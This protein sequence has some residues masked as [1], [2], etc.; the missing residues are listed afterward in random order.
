MYTNIDH[1][2]TQ[3]NTY[4]YVQKHKWRGVVLLADFK[5]KL[6]VS[7]MYNIVARSPKNVTAYGTQISFTC[8]GPCLTAWCVEVVCGGQRTALGGVPQAPST[9]SL[10]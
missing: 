10:R 1:R 8:R 6:L 7:E 3:T 5:H 9:F 4:A 2:T